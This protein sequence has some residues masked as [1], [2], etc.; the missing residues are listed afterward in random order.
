MKAK[1]A[2]YGIWFVSVLKIPLRYNARQFTRIYPAGKRINSS[3]FLPDVS[4]VIVLLTSY[5]CYNFSGTGVL[6]VRSLH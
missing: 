3:N 1:M 2:I 5:C 4:I 6:V